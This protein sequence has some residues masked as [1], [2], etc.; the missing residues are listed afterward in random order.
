[1][2]IDYLI[3]FIETY[4]ENSISKACKK[5]HLT[6]SALS[7]QLQSLEKSLDSNLLIRSNKG[8]TLTEEGDIVASYA[9]TIINLYDNM[10]KELQHSKQSLINEIK[11]FSCN[12]VGEYLLPCTLHLYKKNHLDIRFNLKT[13]KTKDV[14][15]NILDC[16]A[17]IGFIDTKF[18][19]EGIECITV[20]TGN[21]VFIY[22]EKNDYIN[23]STISL[24]EIYKLPLIMGP[25]ESFLR[26]SIE[27]MFFKNN[28]NVN[29]LN[30][31]IE[32][33]TIESIKASVIAN[34]GVSILPYTSVKK[35]L[36]SGVLRTTPIEDAA[37]KHN[38]CMIYQKNR[39]NHPHIK[40][41]ISYIKKYGKETF[42]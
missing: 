27:D 20:S 40:D 24:N 31:E 26:Q 42:C 29:G 28:I 19:Q 13:E 32:L 7:Q 2:N 23:A 3:S 10:L 12:S 30:I 9:E 4:R 16:S 36:Y 17:D 22:S 1:M 21:L 11:I 33:D 37:P 38:I 35:E 8:V 14:I 25:K 39:A 6:Q 15:E 41:F 5:L 34:H 18:K